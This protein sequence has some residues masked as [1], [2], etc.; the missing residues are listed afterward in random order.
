M[1]HGDGAGQRSVTSALLASVEAGVDKGIFVPYGKYGIVLGHCPS[2]PVGV[3]QF[4]IGDVPDQYSARPATDSGLG[5]KSSVLLGVTEVEYAPLKASAP[6]SVPFDEVGQGERQNRLAR[7]GFGL[8]GCGGVGRGHTA[9]VGGNG[10]HPC[11]V[12][13]QEGVPFYAVSNATFVETRSVGTVAA[14]RITT[15]SVGQR[16]AGIIESSLKDVANGV[17]GRLVVDMSDVKVL[18]SMGLGMLVTLTKHCRAAGGR[19]AIYGI[20]PSL[21]ELL[22]LTRLDS[23]LAIA[24]DEASAIRAIS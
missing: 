9:S 21:L 17:K 23:F 14:A 19:L 12:A 13:R 18:G 4:G 22:K 16:E 1:D 24:K 7:R 20:D 11:G 5:P 8:E 6:A 10:I 15:N 2:K 3:R